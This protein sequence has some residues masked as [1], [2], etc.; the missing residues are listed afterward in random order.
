MRKCRLFNGG[1]AE[2]EQL[3]EVMYGYEPGNILIKNEEMTRTNS[4]S[5]Y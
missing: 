2:K 1:G 5:D 3:L 4:F